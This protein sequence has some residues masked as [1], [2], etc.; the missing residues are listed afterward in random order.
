MVADG[1][2][3]ADLFVRSPAKQYELP[4]GRPKTAE[5]CPDPMREV[6]KDEQMNKRDDKP[7]TPTQRFEVRP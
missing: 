2:V 4:V 5:R 6:K 1:F 7:L 3:S